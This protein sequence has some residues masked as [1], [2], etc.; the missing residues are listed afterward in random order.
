M[1]VIVVDVILHA[2]WTVIWRIAR[3]KSQIGPNSESHAPLSPANL[4]GSVD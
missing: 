2:S 4:D 1:G 3:E